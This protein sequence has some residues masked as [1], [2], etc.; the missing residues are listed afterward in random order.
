ML[1]KA[2]YNALASYRSIDVIILVFNIYNNFH[3][4]QKV[5]RWKS[6]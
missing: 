4:D 5:G 3:N 6:H 1:D 2:V